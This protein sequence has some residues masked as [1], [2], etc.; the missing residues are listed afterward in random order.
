M[1]VPSLCYHLPWMVTDGNHRLAAAIFRGDLSIEASVAGELV[2][3]RR[4]F[5]IDCAEP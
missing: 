3:A 5:G 4:H 2:Y 1:W